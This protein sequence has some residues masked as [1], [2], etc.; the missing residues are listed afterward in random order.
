MKNNLELI[1]LK[2]NPEVIR[3][4][5]I[6]DWANSVYQLSITSA[7]LPAYYIAVAGGNEKGF[8]SFFGF[9]I[10]DT[11]LY[12]WAVSASFLIVALFSPLLSSIADSTGKR[13]AFMQFFTILG[14]SSCA[15]LYFFTPGN[16]EFGIITFTLAGIGYSGGLVFYNAWLPEIA[17]SGQEDR[18][19]ARGFA[20]GY[21]GGVILL[22]INL[23]MILKSDFFGI[24]GKGMPARI[25]F[26]TVGVWWIFF[27][28]FTF[29]KL[30][31]RLKRKELVKNPI[32]NGY[33]ELRKV[34]RIFREQRTM[35]L[36]L[37][38][39]FFTMMAVLTVMYM[40]ANFGKKELGLKDE[41][42]IPTILIIQ[43]V[44]VVGAIFF[45]RVSERIGNINTLLINI[46]IWIGICLGAWFV[47]SAGQFM[48]LAAV[49]G[50]VM[51]AVQALA[52]SSWS[53]LLPTNQDNTA[54]FSFYDVAEKLAVVTGTFLFGLLEALTGSMRVSVVM[55]AIV[56][57]IAVLFFWKI[58][59]DKRLLPDTKI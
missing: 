9:E 28:I 54:Y 8:V 42:L 7:I 57:G 26:I 24:E 15:A 23:A 13:K 55:L 30:P 38:G 48:I 53:K 5:T 21:I 19:S 10:V 52:R 16:L 36:Y 49:V 22:L 20:L 27:S 51:G 17:P 46:V 40:A 29:R 31:S 43:L 59:S 25:S 56:F 11:S 14:A 3:A 47:K 45:A 1:P 50:L 41:V 4:W 37:G 58:R 34:W 18:I 32:S 6:Y 33:L 2:G 39:F 35:K 12:A 44:G